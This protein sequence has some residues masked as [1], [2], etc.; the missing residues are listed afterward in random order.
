MNYIHEMNDMKWNECNGVSQIRWT[1]SHEWNEMKRNEMKR[2]ETKG[3]KRNEVKSL[4]WS[5]LREWNE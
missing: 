5:E 4:E 3:N 2:N 1:K